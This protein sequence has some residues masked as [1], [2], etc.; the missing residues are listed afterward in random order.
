MCV[1]TEPNS[2]EPSIV[3]FSEVVKFHGHFCGG[4]TLGYIAAKIAIRELRAG[5]DEDEQLVA[6]V[7]NDACGLD[8]IQMVSGCTIGK[9]NLIL[10]NHGK[11]VYTFINRVTNDAVRISSK[12]WP[13][14]ESPDLKILREKV[15]AGTAN[16]D[17]ILLKRKLEDEHIARML[18]EPPE[19][20]FDV[21]HV[22]AEIPGKAR[23]FNSVKCAKCGEMV[24][25]SRAR[26]QDGGIVCIPCYDEYTR[27]W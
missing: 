24:A 17:E 19:K 26:V 14:D 7:E 2:H 3:P 5:R 16:P 15:W 11:H 23:I 21:K 22:K 9:G 8:A 10:R 18:S 13:Q 25:E 4:I 1:G 12:G 20:Y 27:G 6:I